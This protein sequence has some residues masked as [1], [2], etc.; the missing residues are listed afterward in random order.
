M[1]GIYLSAGEASGDLHAGAVAAEIARRGGPGLFGM[2][3]RTMAAAGVEITQ[4]I[5]KLAVMGFAEVVASYRLIR[6]AF[7][8]AVETCRARRPDVAVLVDYP[9]FHLR[10]AAALKD[11]GIPVVL[12]IAPQVWAWKPGR[13]ATVARV[14]RKLLVIFE[15]EREIFARA[16][17][18]VEFVGHPL[19]DEMPA[20]SPGGA[21]R[22]SLGIGPDVP[23][24]GLFPGSRRQVYRRLLPIFLA[25]ARQIAVS[26]PETVFAMGTPDGASGPWASAFPQ[27][28]PS[29]STIDLLRDAT[30]G[31][32]NSGTMS[33]QGAVAG[34]PGFVGYT[35]GWI[36]YQIAK[37]L[38]T[39][40]RV[41]L[42][43][44]VLA[45]PRASDAE[46]GVDAMRELI[47]GELTSQSAAVEIL[48]L[49][50]DPRARERAVERLTE[51]RKRLGEPGGAGRAAE[52]ILHV[53][54]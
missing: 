16:G 30:A 48:R 21:A 41:G 4:S 53:A 25:A 51:V 49:V 13:T 46:R 9:A 33:L 14:A 6:A 40:P 12:Y 36:N 28:P 43:N 2:G 35:M 10:L 3:G 34:C 37:R 50:T 47:Q 1:A 23:L 11:L 42:P 20:D 31:M 39:L 5:D 8:G 27:A 24:V 18:D 17:V 44:I 26:R 15:F 22:R 19:L 52:A 7:Q 45:G 32:Y 38:V 29:V 54:G